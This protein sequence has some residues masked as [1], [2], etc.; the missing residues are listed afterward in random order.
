VPEME[1]IGLK[2]NSASGWLKIMYL[3]DE[4][5]FLSDVIVFLLLKIP[6]TWSLFPVLYSKISI[7]LKTLK[8]S[9]EHSYTR[10]ATN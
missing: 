1:Q 3:K 10:F 9:A 4:P 2:A 6:S 5:S 7:A 8:N